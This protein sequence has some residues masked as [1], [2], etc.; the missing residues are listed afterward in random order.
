[1]NP[2]QKINLDRLL[3]LAASNDAAIV[4]ALLHVGADVDGRGYGGRRST[5]PR[6]RPRVMREP[7]PTFDEWIAAL[8][9]LSD[10]P[11]K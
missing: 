10:E 4:E 3:Y 1:M 5:A 2:T 11:S 6:R 8:S 9:D 7:L